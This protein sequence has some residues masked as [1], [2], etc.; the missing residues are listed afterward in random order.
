M[1][2]IKETIKWYSDTIT[3]FHE[4]MQSLIKKDEEQEINPTVCI[5]SIEAKK[6]WERIFNKITTSQNDE[7]ENEYLKSMYPK[8]KSYIP[9]FA[10]LIHVFDSCL[11]ESKSWV[12]ISKESILKAEKLSDYFVN[13]AKKIKIESKENEDLRTLSKGALN[14]FDKVK[15]I[16]SDDPKFSRSK[17]AELLGLS[18]TMIYKY[19]DKIDS[20]KK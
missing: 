4:V 9:R 6:E 2:W 7:D 19:I 16:Y 13:N 15:A 17:T 10:L 14:N 8:Q 5:F 12:E 3:R 18:R 11:N 20:A 1:K